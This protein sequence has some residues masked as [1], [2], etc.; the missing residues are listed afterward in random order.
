M[1]NACAPPKW[2]TAV[3]MKAEDGKSNEKTRIAKKSKVV[4][5]QKLYNIRQSENEAKKR[6]KRKWTRIQKK[7]KSSQL[8]HMSRGPIGCIY[9]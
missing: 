1:K 2:P 4:E 7:G 5:K 3:I 8:E 9:S 6:A